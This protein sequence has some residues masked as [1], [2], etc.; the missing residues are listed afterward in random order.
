MK[1]IYVL[2][3]A[4]CPDG[5]GAAYSIW[6]KYKNDNINYIAVQHGFALPTMDNESIVWLVDFCYSVEIM[7]EIAQRMSEVLVLDHHKSAYENMQSFDFQKYPHVKT[8][9]DMEKS[10]AVITWEYFHPNTEVPLFLK[11]IQD[12]DLWQFYLPQSKEFSAGLRAY[13]F[14]FYVWEKL[15][16]EDLIKEGEVLL[17]FQNQTIDKICKNARVTKIAGF[18][19]LIVNSPI[20]QSEIGNHLCK[21]NPQ[22]PFAVVYFDVGNQRNFSLRSVGDFDVAKI[23]SKFGGGGHKN[24]AGFVKNIQ[25]WE[26]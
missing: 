19:V 12:K 26:V 6:K 21:Q 25:T 15:N 1:K 2:Y 5:F 10:G 4:Q 23:A 20:F 8:I 3:H 13:N 17:K 11:Y 16:V 14:D 9:F 7:S 18:E 24:A 22:Y